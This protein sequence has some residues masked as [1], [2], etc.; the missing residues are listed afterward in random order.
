[1]KAVIIL[2]LALFVNATSSAQEKNIETQS[3]SIENLITFIVENYD[4][5]T[6]DEVQELKN[7]SFLLQVSNVNQSVE[8][9]VILKQAFKLL[10]K[11]LNEDDRISIITYSGINGVA[12]GQTSPKELKKL[13][14]TID[15]LGSSVKEFHEDGIE[16]AYEYTKENFIEESINSVVM[17]RNPN[18]SREVSSNL[19][20]QTTEAPKKKSN[21]VLL[22]AITLLPEI[23]AVIKN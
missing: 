6:E 9:A 15:N 23:I 14:Y 5:A 20:T 4:T 11:R 17:I 2:I 3:V 21:A 16:L 18:I 12:L 19:V 13:L 7:I 10:S 8:A 22:T 1:M